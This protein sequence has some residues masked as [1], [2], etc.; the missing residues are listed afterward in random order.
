MLHEGRKSIM[1][2]EISFVRNSMAYDEDLMY[3]SFQVS[4]AIYPEQGHLSALSPGQR[5]VMTALAVVAILALFMAVTFR[6][7]LP[8]HVAEQLWPSSAKL[9][10]NDAATHESFKNV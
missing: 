6:C 1:V 5:N 7:I 8:E 4:L 3:Q 2:F 9:T 10:G